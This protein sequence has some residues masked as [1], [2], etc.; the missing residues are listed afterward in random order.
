MNNADINVKIDLDLAKVCQ[1]SKDLEIILEAR[2]E[3]LSLNPTDCLALLERLNACVSV[4][5]KLGILD[6]CEIKYFKLYGEAMPP[7]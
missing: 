7:L 1:H 5:L 2:G 3:I 6:E 4:L